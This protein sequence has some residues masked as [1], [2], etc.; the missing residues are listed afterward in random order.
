[1]K[2]IIR[3]TETDLHKMVNDCVKTILKENYNTENFKGLMA[4][5]ALGAMSM[6]GSP[7]IANIATNHF[8]SDMLES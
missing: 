4:A 6:F 1:M 7:Q 8:T 5:G 2:K 3:L